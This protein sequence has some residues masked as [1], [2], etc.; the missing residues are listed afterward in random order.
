MD[1]ETDKNIKGQT[2]KKATIWRMYLLI[3]FVALIIFD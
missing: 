1:E 2:K 3:G